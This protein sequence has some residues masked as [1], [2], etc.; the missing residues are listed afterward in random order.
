[1]LLAGCSPAPA[2]APSLAERLTTPEVCFSRTYDAAHLAAH[3]QQTV[4]R[5]FLG[6]PG[7]EWRSIQRSDEFNLAFGFQLVGDEDVYSGIGVCR[8]SEA[9]ADC[10]IEGDGGRFT[11]EANGDGVRI[12][13]SRM[14]VEG[15]NDFSPDLALA[16]NRVILLRPAT[17][18]A[19]A[20]S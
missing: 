3:P 18:S 20:A 12:R 5:F 8:S 2:H 7:D 15:P 14:E 10:D 11:I 19:C 13:V 1:V 17:A 6:D 4:R 9:G 16:D